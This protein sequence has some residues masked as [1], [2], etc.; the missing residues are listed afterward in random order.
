MGRAHP[1]NLLKDI[2]F[3]LGRRHS[4]VLPSIRSK[5]KAQ[6]SQSWLLYR[7]KIRFMKK[8]AMKEK[9]ARSWFNDTLQFVNT[10]EHMIAL[11]SIILLS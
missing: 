10:C 5:Y 2:A 1:S 11:I 4:G 8:N 6:K 7:N 3:L 9:I